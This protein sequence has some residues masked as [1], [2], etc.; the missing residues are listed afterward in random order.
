MVGGVEDFVVVFYFFK[1]YEVG[2]CIY[3]IVVVYV[4]DEV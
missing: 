4:F 2:D 1:L 3:G